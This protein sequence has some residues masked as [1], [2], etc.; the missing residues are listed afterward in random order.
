MCSVV[1]N[2]L[3]FVEGAQIHH[4]LGRC[5]AFSE[6][7]RM[8]GGHPFARTEAERRPCRGQSE[9]EQSAYIS[10]T[11]LYSDDYGM[12]YNRTAKEDLVGAGV[13]LPEHA[14]PEFADRAVL[15]N[16][17]EK[18]EKA[19]NAQLARS[20]KYS[21]PNEWDEATARQ[22]MERFIKEQFVN[23]GMCADYGIHRSYNDKGQPNLHIHILLTLRPLNEDGTWGAKSRKEYVLDADGNRIPNASGKGYKSRKVNVI[24]WNEKGKAKEWRNAI[25]E[26]IN[27][28]NEK[29]GIAERVDPRSYKDRGIP[30]I[31]T[32]HLGERASAL[33][34]KG[35]RTERGN[36]NRAIEKYNAMIMKIYGFISELKEELK[37]GV[38][39]FVFERKSRTERDDIQSI[40]PSINPS[41]PEQKSEVQTALE[42]LQKQRSEMVVRPIF[43]YVQ[44]FKDKRLLGNVEQLAKL[45]DTNH[46]ETWE[47]I[48]AFE[49][50]QTE[51]LEKCRAELSELSVRYEK[52]TQA[53]SD[54]DDYKQY[55]PVMKEYQALSGLRQ[56]SFKKKHETELENYAIYR[57]RV[58]AVMPENMKISKPY[59]DKQLAEVLAQQ[60]QIQRKSSRIATDLARLSVFKGNL[61]EMEVQQRADEQAREQNRDKKHENTI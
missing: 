20:L 12:T 21:L 43:P 56:N 2:S 53:V 3:N 45:L 58:K 36:I 44:R 23:K 47:D 30:L 48:R 11:S 49:E 37:K 24:D 17:V 61:R 22:V 39:K 40:N 16:S 35:I 32:I 8:S 25:A 14:P 5:C 57:D 4:P 18:N 6:R 13:L 59:I 33:E 34:R 31:P 41:V 1:V 54:Y 9:V 60:E 46:L 26:I 10:R 38:F 15:W 29:A 28:T 52:W 51:V 27:A 19:K 55:Q 7:C 42:M 50:K